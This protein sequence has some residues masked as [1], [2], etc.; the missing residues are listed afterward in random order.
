V[1]ATNANLDRVVAERGF[2]QD[3]LYRLNGVTLRIPALRER[4]AD[5]RP[6]AERFLDEARRR[7]ASPARRFSSAALAAL[8]KY[9][10]PGNIR[11]LQH[12]VERS[13][14]LAQ[15]E[16][17]LEADLQLAP[18]P[19]SAFVSQDDLARMTLEQAEAWFVQQALDRHHGNAAE[20]AK[21]LGISRS[22]VYRRLGKR[23]PS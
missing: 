12:V 1:S 8:D 3:L 2:R 13:V 23:E 19:S 16:K 9:S 22:A 15:Q 11:E 5:I 21:S 14:L 7:Y 10:W 6:L 4:R 20:A 17:I 18:A